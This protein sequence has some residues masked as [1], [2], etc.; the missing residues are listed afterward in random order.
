[1]NVKGRTHG[2]AIL[3]T[4]LSLSLLLPIGILAGGIWSYLEDLHSASEIL[5]TSLSA[6]KTS[7]RKLSNED[8]GIVSSA[9]GEVLHKALAQLAEEIK[10]KL[11]IRKVEEYEIETAVLERELGAHRAHGYKVL[12]SS[13]TGTKTFQKEV[14]KEMPRHLYMD[15][16]PTQFGSTVTEIGVSVIFNRKG[17]F[18]SSVLRSLGGSW[19][20]A[21]ERVVPLRGDYTW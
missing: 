6:L 18:Y 2:M 16:V 10:E 4:T 17:T 9:N 7:S 14:W 15:S 21:E 12:S 11:K 20:I 13:R 19:N 3:E 8:G 1:M 5:N